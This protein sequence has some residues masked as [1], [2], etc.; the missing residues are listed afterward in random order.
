MMMNKWIKIILLFSLTI[1]LGW[2]QDINDQDLENYCQNYIQNKNLD[3]KKEY[4]EYKN[5]QIQFMPQKCFDKLNQQDIEKTAFRLINQYHQLNALKYV[6]IKFKHIKSEDTFFCTLPGA[7]RFFN[8]KIEKDK[9]CMANKDCLGFSVVLYLNPKLYE[10]APHKLALESIILH[11]L[12]HLKD[13]VKSK[14]D[15]LKLGRKY[16][17]KPSFR[18]AYERNTDLE[19]MSLNP[20]NGATGLLLYRQ[21]L[22]PQLKNYDDFLEK[23]KSYL[24]PKLLCTAILGE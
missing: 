5:Y 22:Y 4:E 15:I 21:W 16:V 17:F 13:L 24:G 12:L 1:N 11:E 7:N 6:N 3:L 14:L 18:L 9:K 20:K 10:C 8:I 2:S 19:V 23:R